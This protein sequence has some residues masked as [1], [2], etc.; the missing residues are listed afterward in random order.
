MVV[1][2]Q[3]ASGCMGSDL[4]VVWF[5]IASGCM[6]S[7]LMVVWF[8]I[9]S[10]CKG[11]DLMVVWFQISS[12]CMGSDLM[13]V[14]FQIASGCKGSELMVVWFQ[15]AS[16]CKGSDTQWLTW[17]RIISLLTHSVIR[18]NS[19]YEGQVDLFNS[20]I[21]TCLILE[22]IKGTKIKVS[23]VL[24]LVLSTEAMGKPLANKDRKY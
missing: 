1:C 11:S 2:V 16:G 4:M 21:S 17:Q 20:H 18:Q 23:S 14:W 13:V 7:E 15:I 9:A 24:V 8:Q 6:G 19:M 5:Q 10:G 22:I 3:I 12:G